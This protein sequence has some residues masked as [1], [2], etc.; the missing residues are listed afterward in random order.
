MRATPTTMEAVPRKIPGTT[1]SSKPRMGAQ[2]GRR[3]CG[4]ERSRL[5][6]WEHASAFRGFTCRRGQSLTSYVR[7]QELQKSGSPGVNRLQ[8]KQYFMMFYIKDWRASSPA[9]RQMGDQ[10][11]SRLIVSIVV[12]QK[13]LS[14]AVIVAARSDAIRR[15]EFATTKVRNCGW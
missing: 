12:N 4:I 8:L 5:P 13:I 6:H 1:E 2:P 15:S 3:G 10:K 11:P 14:V 9:L 7:P